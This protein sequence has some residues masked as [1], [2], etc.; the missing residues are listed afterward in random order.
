MTSFHFNPIGIFHCDKKNPYEAARQARIDSSEETAVIQLQPG[1]NFEQALIGL[2]QFSHIWLIFA[3]HNNH[4]WKPM[5]QPPHGTDSKIGVFATRAPYRPNSIG[6]SCVQLVKIEGLKIYVRKF[7]LLDQTPIL[8]IKPYLA[9]AD[10]FPESSLGWTQPD[11]FQV[12]FSDLARTQLE[13][14]KHH[15]IGEF[16]NFLR[17][18]LQYAPTDSKRKRVHQI[19]PHQFVMAYRTWRAVFHVKEDQVYI[20]NLLSGYSSVDLQSHE[21]PYN[22]KSIHRAFQSYCANSLL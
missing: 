6:M 15:N 14:L 20:E 7:D 4:H 17:Q 1:L 5:V 2:E 9:Y 22:D 18:Q 12:Q 19:K 16:E 3:F 11:P 10:S 13:F 8:D 21:D